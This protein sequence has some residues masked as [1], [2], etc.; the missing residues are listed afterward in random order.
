MNRA[1]KVLENARGV[2]CNAVLAFEPENVFYLTGFW[3][4][5]IAVITDTLRLVVPSLEVDRAAS[6]ARCEIVEAERGNMLDKA[7]A[8]IR[9]EDKVCTDC[10]DYSMLERLKIRLV[11]GSRVRYSKDV[12]YN[13]RMVKDKDEIAC[14]EKGARILD[15]LFKVCK[16]IIRV[17]VSEKELQAMLLYE[18][19]R[20]GAYPPS[21][22]YT[23]SP[24]IVASGINSALPHA[25]PSDRVVEYGDLV[26]VDLTLRYK[27]YVADATRTFAVG[28]IDEERYKIY[29]M[30]REAQTRA[31]GTLRDNVSCKDVDAAARSYIDEKGYG[32]RFIHS[33]GHGIGLDVHE[34]PWI[35]SSSSYTL[36]GGMAVT[37]EPGI[38]LQER[39]GVRIEDSVVVMNNN[40]SILNRYTKDLIVL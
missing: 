8:Y 32:S 25:E 38:Y 6:N 23:L 1:E 4:E 10:N 36:R 15:E 28:R 30:V 17:G 20:M 19:L 39:F 34:P 16:H 3:G 2:A 5:G 24:L 9:E 27:G 40:A 13:A 21:Y 35:S 31:L 22:R 12:F 37:I 29:E 18:A 33:T 26:T 14:I 11:E 7:L